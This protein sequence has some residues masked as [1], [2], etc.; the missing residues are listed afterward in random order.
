MM[1]TCRWL[2]TT[3][4]ASCSCSVLFRVGCVL[5]LSLFSRPRAEGI[6]TAG[7]FGEQEGM[8]CSLLLKLPIPVLTFL[9]PKH[10]TRSHPSS[11]IWRSAVTP[12]TWENKW[13]YLVDSNN[14]T[15]IYPLVTKYSVYSLFLHA[16]RTRS[17]P[18]GVAQ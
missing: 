10:V 15:T 17:L 6:A 18:K 16:E 3:S 13:G 12:D 9:W 1:P 7:N 14:G 2:R 8:T 11:W 5:S 4:L